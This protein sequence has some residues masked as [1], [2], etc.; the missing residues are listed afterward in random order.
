M[1]KI[2][3]GFD[4]RQRVSFTTLSAS[5][6][7]HSSE[8]ISI[9]PLVLR[10]LPITRRGLTPFTFSRFLVPWLCGFEGRAVFLDAD[11]LLVSDIHDAAREI[12]PG[13]AVAVVKSIAKFE[14]TSFMVFDCEHPANKSLTPEYIQNTADNLHGL[15]WLDEEHIGS[16]SSKWN[17]LV[18]YQQVEPSTGNLHYTMGVPAYPE[19]STCPQGEYWK[20]QLQ[21]AT[22]SVPW[23]QIMGDSVHAIEIDGVKFPKYVWDI[24]NNTPVDEHL[25]LLQKLIA[26]QTEKTK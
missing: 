12:E 5:I 21:L 22:S 7:E 1:L 17:Q 11:M 23:V 18:G 10:T 15:A 24:E 2:F 14:Q 20:A 16:L 6:Y 26:E 13:H 9:T 25:E 19:T 4:E 8:P 3:I